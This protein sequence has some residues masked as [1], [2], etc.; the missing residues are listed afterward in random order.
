[1]SRAVKVYI[2][3]TYAGI[4]EETDSGHYSFRYDTAYYN[5]PDMPPVSLTMPKDKQEYLSPFL[6]PVFFNMTSEGDNRMIQSRHLHIDER[7]DFGILSATAHTD[8]IGAITVRPVKD[9]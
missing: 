1:M 8:T 7:D 4:L 9:D 3:G 6:F 2:K 5:N